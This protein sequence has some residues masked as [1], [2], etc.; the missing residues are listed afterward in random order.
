MA[1]GGLVRVFALL[2]PPAV[3]LSSV[4]DLYLSRQHDLDRTLAVLHPFWIAAAAAVVGAALLQAAGGRTGARPALVAYYVA[5]TAFLAWGLLRAL[6]LGSH[7]VRWLLDTDPG[8]ALFLAA[9]L[10]STVLAARRLK[11][12]TLEPVLAVLCV[13]LVAREAVALTTR[14]DRSPA[15]PP[16]D[17]V[18][19]LGGAPSDR[20]NVYHLILDSFQDE[21]LEPCLPPGGEAALE[22]FVRFH[23]VSPA[24]STIRVV[25]SIFT[26]QWLPGKGPAE[27]VRLGLTGE[28]SL[29]RDLRR[30]GY[31]TLGLVPRFLYK[32][33]PDAFDVVVFHDDNVPEGDRRAHHS[34]SFLRLW[35]HRTLPVALTERLARG[36]LFGV[37]RNLFEMTEAESASSLSKPATSL[38]S[39]RS[40]VGT[41]PRLPSRGRYTLVHVALPHGPFRLRSDCA[42]AGSEATDLEQQTRCTL[43]LL[44]G[45]VE[46]LRR[47]D[48][49]DGSVVLVQGDHGMGQT[50]ESGR[51][52]ED[53]EAWLR[54]V[55][56]VKPRGARGPMRR[57][58]RTATMVDVAPTLLA[59]LG[60]AR[61]EPFDG[62]V[63]SEAVA[64]SP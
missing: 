8:V 29:L 32:L 39:M 50:L 37:G 18:A 53:E 3:A 16:R 6:P 31:R 38:L 30:A 56:L 59:L 19:E 33:Q 41:E 26:G 52:V 17:V 35:L 63:L 44:L 21:L 57:A 27:R 1:R 49:L 58:T 62:Q 14:L 55:V 9:W 61:E 4:H 23:A 60:I 34:A 10:G 54:T 5:G 47:L 42:W 15:A 36:A 28:A 46:T 40:F 51:I 11:P 7:F 13:V 2:F 48:R 25:P 20:P 22:G 45:F 64:A 24:P 12:R 43:S